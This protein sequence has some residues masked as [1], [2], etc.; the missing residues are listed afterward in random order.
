MSSIIVAFVLLGVMGIIFGLVLAVASKKLAV[1]QDPRVEQILGVLPGAN[2]GGC[3][4]PGCGGL[5]D[6]IV[7]GGAPVNGCPVGKAPVAAKVAEIMGVEVD[8]DAK[9]K[10]AKVACAGGKEERVDRFHYFGVT[11]CAAAQLLNGGPKLCEFGCLGLGNCEEVCKFD[12]IHVN[13]NGIPE[14]DPKRCTA[15]GACV[16]ECPRHLIKLV[17]DTCQVMVMCQSHSKGPEV[18]KACKVGCLGCGICAKNCPN[19]AVTVT[20]FLASVN[21]ELCTGCGICVEKCPT[22][23]IKSFIVEK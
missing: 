4:F 12:A 1:D 13:A 9:P 18:R 20:D 7:N 22:K 10:F 5:A 15:C 16:A 17:D 21:T 11:D 19:G 2:C 8:L 23:A 3:G 14:V 6:A